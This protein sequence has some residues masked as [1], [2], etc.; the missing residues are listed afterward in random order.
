[1]RPPLTAA[2]CFYDWLERTSKCKDLPLCDELAKFFDASRVGDISMKFIDDMREIAFCPS[3]TPCTCAKG[4]GSHP[5][6]AASDA[7]LLLNHNWA[8]D[9]RRSEM[10][11]G[12]VWK[13]LLE[14]YWEHKWTYPWA[15]FPRPGSTASELAE[16]KS[17]ILGPMYHPSRTA[18]HQGL[19]LT[20][21]R[22]DP[23]SKNPRKTLRNKWLRY[24]YRG[25]EAWPD[26]EHFP[27][28]SGAV[29]T[30]VYDLDFDED[31][32]LALWGNFEKCYVELSAPEGWAASD[33]SPPAALGDRAPVKLK[34]VNG[35]TV[36]FL[37]VVCWEYR[38][39]F[40]SSWK[41]QGII[42]ADLLKN[43]AGWLLFQHPDPQS[44][45]ISTRLFFQQLEP[46]DI[47]E[48]AIMWYALRGWFPV[49]PTSTFP[50]P[51]Q[52]V[53][54]RTIL[55]LRV[56]A[57]RYT[58]DGSSALDAGLPRYL[59]VLRDMSPAWYEDFDWRIDD[60]QD[61]FAVCCGW[62]LGTG[63]AL[64][65]EELERR[66]RGQ[67]TL[68]PAP[69]LKHQVSEYFREYFR[70]AVQ[71][72]GRRT[73]SLH[74][75]ISRYHWSAN[76][77]LERIGAMFDAEWRDFVL[78]MDARNQV[79]WESR[80]RLIQLLHG[81]F[82]DALLHNES[83]GAQRLAVIRT[84]RSITPSP[85]ST[86][87]FDDTDKNTYLEFKHGIEG[88]DPNESIPFLDGFGEDSSSDEE[89]DAPEDRLGHPWSR[90][91]EIARPLSSEQVYRPKPIT[92]LDND[93]TDPTTTMTSTETVFEK[94]PELSSKA[95][96]QAQP[97][98]SPLLR[99]VLGACGTALLLCLVSMS[100]SHGWVAGGGF[101]PGWSLTLIQRAAPSPPI[102]RITRRY[103]AGSAVVLAED[104]CVAVLGAPM[105]GL[106][107]VRTGSGRLAVSYYAG[108]AD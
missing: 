84:V 101:A 99:L 66:A 12:W 37:T 105:A 16:S 75:I 44:M 29:G 50:A 95:L 47:N 72:G 87:I 28:L 82:D 22:H 30:M 10:I 58:S 19:T 62:A 23:P 42:L 77:Q 33:Y 8:W 63:I 91:E 90:A 59:N 64:V 79:K 76:P 1:M 39:V 61:M 7:R 71:T 3:Q 108:G 40:C 35:V 18:V 55:L 104:E 107:K 80:A 5:S 78:R 69:Q 74:S 31:A 89:D 36:A 21:I 2:E 25:D 70:V 60:E 106:L 27:R 11:Q 49:D 103:E 26:P 17:N 9:L 86:Q 57:T 54:N 81:A 46:R 96:A 94:Q 15:Q 56:W 73:R 83:R 67:R 100:M 52:V 65:A 13:R 98:L 85:S 14:Y 45:S 24:L 93:T 6:C 88:R 48:G 53:F 41:L 4:A 20:L 43:K 97:G 92:W 102:G 32:A 51:R 34:R 38:K 68:A